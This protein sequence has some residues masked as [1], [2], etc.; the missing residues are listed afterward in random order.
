VLAVYVVLLT[1]G[2]VL[3]VPAVLRAID[4]IESNTLV[5][6]VGFGAFV[7]GVCGLLARQVGATG[8]VTF[9]VAAAVG[10]AAGVMTPEVLARLRV[11]DRAEAAEPAD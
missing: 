1:I 7:G 2:V 6:A 3:G 9:I 5:D 11:L 8:I 4:R 10:L